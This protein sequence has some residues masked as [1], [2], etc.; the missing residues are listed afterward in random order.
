MEIVAVPL[1]EGA[2]TLDVLGADDGRT[3]A[4]W[5]PFRV[6]FDDGQPV[7]VGEAPRVAIIAAT[8]TRDGGDWLFVTR[9]G[10]AWTA[11]SFS[12]PLHRLDD[13]A[14][15]RVRALS[16]ETHGAV[17]LSAADNSVLFA[18]A[19]GVRRAP[20]SLRGPVVDATFASAEQ[21][22]IVEQPGRLLEVRD[23]GRT[24]VDRSL[25]DDAALEL[26]SNGGALRVRSPRAWLSLGDDQRWHA[27]QAP[28]PLQAAPEHSGNAIALSAALEP[29]RGRA[30]ALS[31][32]AVAL[33]G[34]VLAMMDRSGDGEIVFLHADSARRVDAPCVSGVLHPFGERVVVECGDDTSGLARFFV[35]SERGF[36][37]VGGPREPL[38]PLPANLVHVARDGTAIVIEQGCN[39]SRKDQPAERATVLCVLDHGHSPRPIALTAPVSRVREVRASRVLFEQ[40]SLLSGMSRDMHVANIGSLSPVAI[41]GSA[42]WRD[43]TLDAEGAVLATTTHAGRRTLVRAVVGQPLAQRPLPVGASR[44]RSIDAQRIVAIDDSAPAFW[45]SEDQGRSWAPLA[46]SVDGGAAMASPRRPTTRVVSLLGGA[47]EEDACASY[48]CLVADGLV[49]TDPSWLR[50]PPIAAAR[51]GPNVVDEPTPP[52]D[53]GPDQRVF[54]CGAVRSN[55]DAPAERARDQQWGGAPGSRG[56]LAIDEHAQRV[57][58]RWISFERELLVRR[59]SAPS[60]IP[61]LTASP[62]PVDYRLR[63]ATSAFAII[64][65]CAGESECDV[66]FAPANGAIRAISA[67][68]EELSG[69]DWSG[70]LHLAE[71]TN[72]QGFALWITRVDPVNQSALDPS[73]RAADVLLSFDQRATLVARRSF[74]WAPGECSMRALGVHTGELGIFCASNER[75][76]TLRFFSITGQEREATVALDR[77]EASCDAIAP[78]EPWMVNTTP[79]WAPLFYL[80]GR[81]LEYGLGVRARWSLG[82]RGACLSELRLDPSS[83]RA[84]AR[85]QALLQGAPTSLVLRARSGSLEALSVGR[86]SVERTPCDAR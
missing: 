51:S 53:R 5:G 46:L 7:V 49:V 70:R 44:V 72:N 48:A 85:L 79:G 77:A 62:S 47:S 68:R 6:A 22:W 56:W 13:E 43:A 16:R 12:G 78:S 24:L 66:L 2:P 33:S 64:E 58:A 41:D 18:S 26:H 27:Q 54:F 30:L 20:E 55:A 67:P 76:S 1:V 69:S 84:S 42:P 28:A 65:R 15:G 17:A 21:G 3:R 50:A 39:G 10:A 29:T 25:G 52:L 11:P 8:R 34:R 9:D 73:Q 19:D 45:L 23:R 61:S 83:P 80:R 82:A 71:A 4:I 86:S 60:V 40:G 59:Q 32:G 74:A 37:P 38:G 57:R 35:G 14:G 75:P 36:E 31:L 63:L 81:A